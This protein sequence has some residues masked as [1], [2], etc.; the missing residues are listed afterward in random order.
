MLQSVRSQSLRRALP[1]IQTRSASLFA[2][3]SKKKN[4]AADEYWAKVTAKDP[5]DPR[6]DI[7]KRVLESPAEKEQLNLTTQEKIM[8]N[9]IHRAWQLHL[10]QQREKQDKALMSQYNKMREACEQLKQGH[11]TLYA[12]AM[13]KERAKRYPVELRIPTETPGEKPWDYTWT[14]PAVE[15]VTPKK[16]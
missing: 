6:A 14:R 15:D 8:H 4:T 7:I 11:P 1:S 12:K 9:T 3:N 2:D 16:K 10:R 13:P 5:R